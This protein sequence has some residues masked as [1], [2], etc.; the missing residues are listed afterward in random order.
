[1]L[2]I[3]KENFRDD[4]I[5]VILDGLVPENHLVRKIENAID[6][7]FIYDKVKDLYSPLGAPSIDPVV[8]I[9]IV[10]IQYLF[11]IPSMRQTIREIEV[12]VAYRWF[13]G[14]SLTEKIPHI[15]ED[16]IGEK[17]DFISTDISFIS[18]LKILPAV[19]SILKPEG[20]VVILIKPQFEA[21]K[22]KVGKG[23]VIR[24]KNI[25]EDV[26]RDTLS[27]FET[28]GFHVWGITYSPIKGGSGN[29]EFLA[30]LK[31]DRPERSMVNTDIIHDI[32][33]ES[34]QVFKGEMS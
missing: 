8:L 17:V 19:H 15:T 21:G 16:M 3:R 13:L 20:S 14:Y 9:K 10:L 34:H 5:N 7:S 29:I 2:T 12:N 4:E 31:K 22:E 24:D 18:V 33:E 26:I 1:M 25:H 23:G 28:E 27:A 32:V 6:F 11:G 30:L